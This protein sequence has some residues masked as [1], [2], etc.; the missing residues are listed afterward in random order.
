M[1]AW[2]NYKTESWE[3]IEDGTEFANE[4]AMELI[5]QWPSAQNLFILYRDHMEESVLDAMA[6]VLIACVEQTEEN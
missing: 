6:K 3:D 5:P 4:K 2:W 1:T